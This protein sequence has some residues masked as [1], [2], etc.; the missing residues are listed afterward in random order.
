MSRQTS[1]GS[2]IGAVVVVLAV[3]AAGAYLAY[4][5]LHPGT[6]PTTAPVLPAAPASAP[7]SAAT[8][9]IQHPIAQAAAPASTST[10]A[11]PALDGSDASM[12]AALIALAGGGDLR[13]LLLPQQ[14]IARIVATIDTLP[15]HALGTLMLPL[16]TPKGAF[17]V[18]EIDGKTV[19]SEQNAA[20]YAPYMLIVDR[21]D[22]KALVAWYVH[23]YPLF[24]QAYRELGYPKGYFNDRLIVVIDNLLAAPTLVKPA[25]LTQS[26][27]FHV[28]A[29]P[30]LESL[31]AGQRLLLRV[32][33]AN[34]AKIKA[35]LRAIRGQLTSKKL[36]PG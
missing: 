20:R 26:G 10:A 5:A 4:K 28:Y 19:I 35:K 8:S 23:V 11:L 17:T 13:S 22:P 36:P 27:P 25:A 34:D 1:T 30:S 18:T 15:R 32:G 33:P 3:I 14:V 2:W 7:T 29:D 9:S 12:A 31:S 21:V 16:H 24:Q 6:V